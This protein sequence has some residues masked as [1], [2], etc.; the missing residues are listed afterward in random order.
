MRERG[1][2]HLTLAALML[3]GTIMLGVA[4]GV[5]RIA[6]AWREASHLAAVAAEAGAGWIDVDAARLGEIALDPAAAS[7]AALSLGD[8]GDGITASVEG[9][10]ICVSVTVDVDPGVLVSVGAGI[11]SVIA[12]ACAEPRRG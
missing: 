3:G 8:D 5:T 7:A 6:G 10:R 11:E 2:V 9:D 4:V 1:A 12:T